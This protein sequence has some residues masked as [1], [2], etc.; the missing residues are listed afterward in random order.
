MIEDVKTI[1]IWNPSAGSADEGRDVRR[2]LESMPHVSICEPAGRTD[3]IEVTCREVTQG[4]ELIVAAGGDGT[5]S[6]V[7]E[8]MMQTEL[9]AYMGVLPLGTGNDLA[10][11]L[12]IPLTPFDAFSVL[13]NGPVVKVDVM[14]LSSSSET[15]C[16]ANM[17]TGGNTGRYL[18]KMTDEI[19]QRWGPFCYLRGV[20]DVLSDL[21][22]YRIRVNCDDEPEEA[23]DVLNV[24]FANGKFSGGGLAVSPKAE[25]D[26]GMIDVIIVR[27]GDPGDIASL[28][29]DYLA[30]D[31]LAHELIEFRRARTVTL[32]AEPA[33]PL[34][35]DGDEVG[36]TPLTTRIRPEQLK[37]IA[38]HRL[39]G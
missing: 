28:A 35:A 19:K 1:A 7:V 29:T 15:R 12:D 37:M 33:M 5:L 36:M 32:T 9:E 26:D 2:R 18:E 22:R 13:T 17:V 38:A 8:G 20:V 14:E 30:G 34:T 10:R 24:F 23:F 6:S 4:A 31:Y 25:L 39:S 27:D 21:Q 11:S 16:C 3:A